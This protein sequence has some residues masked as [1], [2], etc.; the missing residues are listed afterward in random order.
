MITLRAIFVVLGT[1]LSGVNSYRI[2][3]IYPV[4][5]KSHYYVGHALMKGLALE[6]HE[7]TVISPFRVKKPIPNYTEVFLENSWESSRQGKSH[8]AKACNYVLNNE[9][10]SKRLKISFYH[11]RHGQR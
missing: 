4:P 11:S 10:N 3:G 8:L 1:I 5:S 9:R 6:G 7:V 2:L